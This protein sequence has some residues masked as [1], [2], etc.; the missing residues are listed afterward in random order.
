MNLNHLLLLLHHHLIRCSIFMIVFYNPI[1][2]TNDINLFSSSYT[3]HHSPPFYP[4]S[5]IIIIIFIHFSWVYTDVIKCSLNEYLKSLF[6]LFTLIFFHFHPNPTHW[7][8]SQP[9]PSSLLGQHWASSLP[10][11]SVSVEIPFFGRKTFLLHFPSYL[12]SS[13]KEIILLVKRRV[14]WS[15]LS[16]TFSFLTLKIV[17]KTFTHK[18]FLIMQFDSTFN[19]QY[20]DRFHFVFSQFLL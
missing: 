11:Y 16:N 7:V 13:T 10:I 4:T 12:V 5:A 20:L 18:Q 3:T 17:R 19:F 8:Y 1:W 2:L 15:H 14:T 6:I 9:K